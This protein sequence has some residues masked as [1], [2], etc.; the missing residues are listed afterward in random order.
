[1]R[2]HPKREL[3][4]TFQFACV[5]VVPVGLLACALFGHY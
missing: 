1:M 3:Q 2:K 5:F 4:E